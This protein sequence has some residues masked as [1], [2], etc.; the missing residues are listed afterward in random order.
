M[1]TLATAFLAEDDALQTLTAYWE[2]TQNTKATNMKIIELLRYTFQNKERLM[3]SILV[4]TGLPALLR[5][6]Q[7]EENDPFNNIRSALRRV[8]RETTIFLQAE[9]LTWGTRPNEITMQGQTYIVSE[10]LTQDTYTLRDHL[11]ISDTKRNRFVKV[12]L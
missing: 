8:G 1:S 2:R 11:K 6:Q 7:D 5:G 4:V 12:K 9:D 10:I 3:P